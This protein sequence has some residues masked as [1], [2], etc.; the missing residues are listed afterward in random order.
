[1]NN[2]KLSINV[3]SKTKNQTRQGKRKRDI[4]NGNNLDNDNAL[5]QQQIEREQITQQLELKCSELYF[6]IKNKR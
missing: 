4:N 5:T 3:L 1:M 6:Q 2:D